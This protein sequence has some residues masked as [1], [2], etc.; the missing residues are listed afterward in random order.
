MADMVFELTPTT[1]PTCGHDGDG[2]AGVCFKCAEE[3]EERLIAM[4][5]REHAEIVEEYEWRADLH[6]RVTLFGTKGLDGVR[7]YWRV[8]QEPKPKAGAPQEKP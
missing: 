2:R 8:P 6:R 4:T 5:P 1:E 7:P 3:G